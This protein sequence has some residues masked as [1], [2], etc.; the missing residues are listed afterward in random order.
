MNKTQRLEKIFD[1]IFQ[2]NVCGPDNKKVRR[3]TSN[4]NLNADLMVIAEAIAPSQVR[5]SGISYFHKDGKVGSTGRNFEK[6]LKEINRTIYPNYDNTIYHTEIVHSFPGYI[7]KN[8]KKQI[9]KPTQE[10]IRDSIQT[11][12]L[13]DE[14]DLIRPKLILLMGKTA[15]MTFY[16]YLLNKSPQQTL[17][18]IIE[19]ISK[20]SNFD[21]Y[22][23][24]PIIPIQHAS[25]SNPRYFQ[26]LKN[27]KL[28]YLIN[29]LLG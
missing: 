5:L 12:I 17:N 18:R 29:R 3:K 1:R 20:T 26:M 24:I 10:Q 7:I 14:I 23:N 25:G 2:T 21:S 11:R 4:V 15:Y 19:E 9:K 6:L 22:R 16:K 8:D 28:I 27:E 13:Q